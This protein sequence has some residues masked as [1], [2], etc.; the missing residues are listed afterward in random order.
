MSSNKP[1]LISGGPLPGNCGERLAEYF[2]IHKLPPEAE[3]TAFFASLKDK[4]RYLQW[5]GSIKTGPEIMDALPKLELISC[6]GVGYDGIDMAAATARKIAVT[7]TP[8]VLNDCVADTAIALML[9]IMRKY[10]AADRFVRAGEWLKG[11]QPLQTSVHH[12]KMGIVGL[13]R[14]GKT[15]AKRGLGFDMEIGYF[16]RSK[17]PDVS[18][19]YF[20]NLADMARWCD[21]MV[22]ITPGGAETK[23]MIDAKILEAL[24]PKGYLVNV[25]RGSVVD[26]PA[27]IAALKTNKIA[28][29]ALDVFA[30]EP[31]V[32]AD[33]MPMEN[34]V[35]APHVASATA[36]TR[37]AMG[38]LVVDNLIQA[39]EGKPLLTRVN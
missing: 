11:N 17:Q 23:N 28:G 21:V 27:L 37:K 1:D 25:A 16:G 39:L 32:P 30:D 33:F 31:R 18:F 26:E 3:R 35:L 5:G 9:N 24:G 22:V 7:N 10:V 19:R 6:F 8:N 20:A 29:A 4:V 15:I 13:G 2:T 12:K 38:D 14:I 36:E 34:V